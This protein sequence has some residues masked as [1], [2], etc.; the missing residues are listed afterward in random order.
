[1]AVFRSILHVHGDAERTPPAP[2]CLADLL[3]DQVLDG[4]ALGD[5]RGDLRPLFYAWARTVDEVTYR[6]EVFADLAQDRNRAPIETFVQDISAMR[7]HLGRAARLSHPL[8]RQG[9]QL[10]AMRTYCTAVSRLRT[11]LAAADIS[12]RGIRE[13]RDYLDDYVDS[14]T[15]GALSEQTDAVRDTMTSIRY[16]VH[17]TGLHVDVDLYDDQPDYSAQLAEL[18]DRFRQDTVK[19]YHVRIPDYPDMNHVEEHILD[20]V[21]A[22]HRDAF[23]RLAA[24][25]AEHASFF[26]ATLDRFEDEIRFYLSYLKYMRGLSDAGLPFCYPSVSTQF[27]GVY[28]EDAFDLALATKQLADR[29]LPV[30]NAFRLTGRER[31]LIVT[32]PNQGG[33]TT[34]ARTVGQVAY[35]AALGC[36]VPA[37]R[38]SLM[39]PDRV[40]T[41]FERQE[42]ISSLHGKLD[43]ELVRIHAVLGAATPRSVIVMNESFSS[44]TIADALQISTEVLRRIIDIGCVTVYVSF[45]DEL[46]TLDPACV[47]M[48][49]GVEPDDPTMRTFRFSRRPADGLAYADALADKYGL[50]PEVLQRRV[51]R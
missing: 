31:I 32:G 19:D 9:W 37:S 18:F 15:F 44:T 47:S 24:H 51:M 49:G 34:F 20:R 16:T 14:A 40:Y 2:D 5:A 42:H 26:D 35:L 25:C 41:H 4:I 46:A 28:A 6:H 36:P 1:M 38:A 50:S 13:F 22:Q 11:E 45:L 3:L 39:L 7:D 17:V 27:R 48:V 43:D 21:A 29:K 8:Q 12:S 23:A 33:K 30:C 10:H